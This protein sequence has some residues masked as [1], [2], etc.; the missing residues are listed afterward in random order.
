[1]SPQ[2]DPGSSGVYERLNAVEVD[3]ATL[4]ANQDRMFDSDRRKQSTLD[5]VLEKVEGIDTLLRGQGGNP[6]AFGRL[7]RLEQRTKL[8]WMALVA[9]L[10]AA[11]KLAWDTVSS[12]IRMH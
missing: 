12:G 11:L 3:L 2:R 1:M 5:K 7:D 10:G 9:G 4:K 8:V 6:G